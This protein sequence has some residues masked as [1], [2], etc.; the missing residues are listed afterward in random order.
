MCSFHFYNLVDIRQIDELVLFMDIV[1]LNH[2]TYVLCV[3][4]SG[5]ER[6]ITIDNVVLAFQTKK[7]AENAI[8]IIQSNIQHYAGSIKVKKDKTH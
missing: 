7:E 6:L 2:S 8:E 4:V 5:E 3:F 1:K